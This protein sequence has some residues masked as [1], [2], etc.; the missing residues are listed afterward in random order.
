MN[1]KIWVESEYGKGSKFIF[2]IELEER[3]DTKQFNLFSDKKVLVVDDNKS[4]HSILANILEMFNIKVDHAYS[5]E[6]AV[7]KVCKCKECYDLILMD[8]NMPKIDGIEATKIIQKEFKKHPVTIIMISSFRQESIANLAKD[9]GID[10]FLQKPIN[11]SVL[12]DI[13]SGL[14]LDGVDIKNIDTVK[15]DTLKDDLQSLNGSSILIVEDNVINQEIIIG[16]LENSGIKIDIAN[17][18]VEAVD[19]FNANSTKY[20]LILMDLQMPIMGGIEATKIIREKYKDIPIIALT[21]NAMKEDVEKTKLAGMNEHLNKP[22]EVE[23][24]YATLLKFISKK[25][26]SSEIKTKKEEIEL[27]EFTN[28]DISI[29][30][31]YLSNNKKL[32]LKILNDFYESYKDVKLEELSD[33]E[34]KRVT[35]TIKGL[36]ANIGANSLHTIAKELDVTQNK[37]LLPEFYKELNAVIDELEEKLS[38]IDNQRDFK[39]ELD[40]ETRDELLEALKE[41]AKKRRSKLCNEVL[42]KLLSYKLS[43]EDQQLFN[44]L[45]KLVDGR[46]YKIIVEMI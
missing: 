41:Y 9:V 19:M 35:H 8:W 7:K 2:E 34:F 25:E 23:K 38:K 29:G 37:S 3:E 17:N 39:P 44:E 10:I 28:I 42:E 40:T 45:K 46:K 5:G 4:W 13:L 15:E 14:F 33:E 21:A 20:E 31:K 16:L 27:P 12:N 30:L 1:G 36:S 26:S 11:P 18:G 6:E 22:I 43:N 24:L 32:Y